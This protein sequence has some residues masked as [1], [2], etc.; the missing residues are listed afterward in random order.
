[1]SSVDCD[2]SVQDSLYG[3]DWGGCHGRQQRNN[4]V[5]IWCM[6][7]RGKACNDRSCLLL[8]ECEKSKE[9]AQDKGRLEDCLFSS[10]LLTTH[11]FAQGMLRNPAVHLKFGRS[12]HHEHGLS[13]LFHLLHEERELAVRGDKG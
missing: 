11:Q 1:V 7:S 2:A 8:A 3:Y 12:V 9:R 13:L 4:L 6:V 5:S 10:R